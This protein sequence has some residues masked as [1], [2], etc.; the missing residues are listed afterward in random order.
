MTARLCNK[1]PSDLFGIRDE[2]IA[3]YFN[4]ECAETL[5]SW[6]QE[7]EARRLDAMMSGTLLSQFTE[8]PKMNG[9]VRE[10]TPASDIRD[11]SF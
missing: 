9:R 2:E 8:Q 7:Q 11:Q 10:I 5:Y 4:Q 1:S 3:Y 6:E